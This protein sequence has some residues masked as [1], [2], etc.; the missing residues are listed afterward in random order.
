MK[1]LCYEP[2]G[3]TATGPLWTKRSRGWSPAPAVKCAPR[4]SVSRPAGAAP[5][6]AAMSV[7]D[8]PSTM[9]PCYS[10][11]TGTYLIG[12]DRTVRIVLSS[13]VRSFPF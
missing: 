7:S 4:R 6:Q 3:F 5:S 13:G 9:L 12:T 11:A 8:T 2:T 1:F 10:D